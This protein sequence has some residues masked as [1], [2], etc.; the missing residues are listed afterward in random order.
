MQLLPRTSSVTL[1]LT[2]VSLA[3]ACIYLAS[4][5]FLSQHYLG[6]VIFSVIAL[7]L[8]F[9]WTPVRLLVVVVAWV[10]TFIIPFGTIN[11]FYAMDYPSRVPPSVWVLVW[12]ALPWVVGSLTIIH[13]FGKYKADFRLKPWVVT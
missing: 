3:I 10:L 2:V 7:G 11:P 9:L 8:W 12:Q 6:A 5:A 1:K 13:I 4:K